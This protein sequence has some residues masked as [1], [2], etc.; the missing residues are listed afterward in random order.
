MEFY[1]VNIL[2]S[3]IH[4]RQNILPSVFQKPLSLIVA[5]IRKRSI[6]FLLITLAT[7]FT[8]TLHAKH[9]YDSRTVIRIF[10]EGEATAGF[11]TSEG[12]AGCK[13]NIMYLDLSKESGSAMLSQVIAAKS[14]GFKVVRIDYIGGD[15]ETC[16]A[17]GLHIQ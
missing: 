4:F 5:S 17:T 2:F 13:W 12:L 16:L 1:T 10:S 9:F 11:Y 7:I 3:E 8:N 6:F 14:A 15:G